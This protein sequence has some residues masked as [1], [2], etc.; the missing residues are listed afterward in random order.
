MAAKDYAARMAA[1]LGRLRREMNGA[2]ADAMRVRGRAYG[3]NYGVSLPT[4]RTIARSCDPDHDFARY[5]YAQDVRELRL[6]ALTLAV[7]AKVTPDQ[8]DTW[9]AGIVN[10]EVAEEAAFALL[11]RTPSLQGLYAAWIASPEPLLRYAALLAAARSRMI[12][13]GEALAPLGVLAADLPD[14]R[15]VAAGAVALLASVAADAPGREAVRQAILTLPQ[16]AA[17]DRI[18]EEMAWRLDD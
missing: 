8:Y 16:T 5:L 15:L 6:A 1:L 17:A 18:R 14:D 12:P 10:S 2:V 3:L 7:P 4:I 9:A 11:S 13:V